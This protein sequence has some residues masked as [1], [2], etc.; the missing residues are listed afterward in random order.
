MA[1]FR[2]AAL[3]KDGTRV[4]GSIALENEE[5]LAQYLKERELVP[6]KWRKK[7][8]PSQPRAGLYS[9]ILQL[10]PLIKAGLP[11][12]EALAVMDNEQARDLQR[13]LNMGQ[14]LSVAAAHNPEFF[15]HRSQALL[16]AAQA[17][18]NLSGALETLLR[19]LTRQRNTRKKLISLLLYPAMIATV[20]S[21]V[22]GALL[23]FAIPSLKELFPKVPSTGLTAFVFSASDTAVAHE[24]GIVITLS[25][26][27]CGAIFFRRKVKRFF[28]TMLPLKRF[29]VV[30]VLGPLFST[31]GALVSA[32]V[33]L[34][35]S[36]AI[37]TTITEAP[38]A[39]KWLHAVK[40]HIEQGGKMS[41]EFPEW[42]PSLAQKLTI[43]GEQTGTLGP[44]FLQ[45]ANL[46]EE[47]TD[48]KTQALMQALMPAL[49]VVM[50]LI[51]ASLMAAVLVPLTDPSLI[52][53]DL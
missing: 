5:S 9:F 48:R 45:I 30:A 25:I 20:C 50:G 24:V 26:L 29:Q 44:A 18:G 13:R 53:G 32:G 17:S 28:L 3:S 41:T 33:P 11:L 37:A 1:E 36:I 38:W 35:E 12:S 31:L 51:V 47:E 43:V 10:T 23:F 42:I 27:L 2:F 15:D 6:L 49:L 14:S 16:S 39:T 4:S 7:I 46:F 40:R 19:L 22:V 34:T 8:R 52:A 21:F